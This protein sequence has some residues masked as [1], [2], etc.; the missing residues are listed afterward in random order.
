MTTG[1]WFRIFH[2]EPW[3]FMIQFDE[4]I[5]QMGWFNH[6]LDKVSNLSGFFRIPPKTHGHPNRRKIG[7]VGNWLVEVI[8]VVL[9]KT[10]LG[11]GFENG[12]EKPENLIPLRIH[13][14]N[15]IFTYIF[16]LI[17]M[18]NGIFT[19]IFSLI[20]MVNGIFTYIFSL[21]CMVNVE[22]Y[23]SPMDG[24]GMVLMQ[25]KIHLENE[26]LL[27]KKSINIYPLKNP[28]NPV[29]ST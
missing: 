15:G 3:G 12:G 28:K 22:K 16:S 6:Q 14:T 18:V 20:S 17:S 2:P 13:G 7:S 23:T 25:S 21:I 8:G 10:C 4:H 26:Q 9:P 27:E 24:M 29:P 5:F 1:W 19:Y 11:F